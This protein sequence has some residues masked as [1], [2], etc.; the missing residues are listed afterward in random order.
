MI[1][2]IELDSI[3]TVKEHAPLWNT[4]DNWIARK[5]G[6]VEY[7]FSCHNMASVKDTL[8]NYWDVWKNDAGEWEKHKAV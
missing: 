5:I 1:E 6:K 7:V 2:I 3:Q 8:G 4:L